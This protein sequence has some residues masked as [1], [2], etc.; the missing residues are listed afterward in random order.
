MHSNLTVQLT[1]VSNSSNETWINLLGVL[2]AYGV[3]A[4]WVISLIYSLLFRVLWPT[5]VDSFICA[6]RTQPAVS[7]VLTTVSLCALCA[8]YTVCERLKSLSCCSSCSQTCTGHL[9]ELFSKGLYVRMQMSGNSF[10][11]EVIALAKDIINT[12]NFPNSVIIFCHGP[13]QNVC[14]S[15]TLLREMTVTLAVVMHMFIPFF[16]SVVWNH[17][18]LQA[19][20]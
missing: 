10:R 11:E 8:K 3:R 16:Q 12:F 15:R 14:C 5:A 9:L 13:G 6:G 7:W 2:G 17:R 19:D 20:Y 4:W 18:N 1:S